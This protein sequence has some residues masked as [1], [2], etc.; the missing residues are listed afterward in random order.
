MM[1]RRLKPNSP[2]IPR[3]LNLLWTLAPR[4]W[5]VPLI[6]LVCYIGDGGKLAPKATVGAILTT[7]V[8]GNEQVLLTRRGHEPFKGFW[9]L[10][11]GNIDRNERA[12]DAVIREVREET[13][14]DFAPRFWGYWDEIIPSLEIHAVVIVFTGCALGETSTDGDEVTRIG[15]FPIGE[16]VSLPL[17]FTHKEILALLRL[18]R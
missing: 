6:N 9:C 14:L 18:V 2:W 16:A 12:F 15:W 17:A 13:G 1:P 10:P 4:K 11:G 5:R 8:D 3:L 7:F